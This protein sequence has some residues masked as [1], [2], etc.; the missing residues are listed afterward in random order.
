MENNNNNV[1]FLHYSHFAAQHHLS[2]YEKDS[3]YTCSLRFK[4]IY[5]V[6]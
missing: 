6:Q 4:A 2:A 5:I 1:L 3:L